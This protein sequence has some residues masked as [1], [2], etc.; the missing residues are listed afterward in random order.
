MRGKWIDS[1][2]V[3]YTLIHFP[4]DPQISDCD[5]FPKQVCQ[6]CWCITEAF[7]QLYVK[8][9]LAQDKFLERLHS[10]NE[11]DMT[12]RSETIFVEPM[13]EIVPIKCEIQ[14][15]KSLV[16]FN[17]FCAAE[18]DSFFSQ[19][20]WKLKIRKMIL[21]TAITMMAHLTASVILRKMWMFRMRNLRQNQNRNEN[22]D[23]QLQKKNEINSKR[24]SK[25][26]ADSSIWHANT[27]LQ[28]STHFM[29][30]NTITFLCTILV[31]AMFDVVLW[32]C[33]VDMKLCDTWRVI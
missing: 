14:L 21:M 22:Q 30:L 33:G 27:V 2:E 20:S 11:L 13:V 28:L 24:F 8:A 1:N 4:F 3:Y 5:S 26:T 10:K 29:M 19:M 6:K 17:R 7:H 16:I 25:S 32:N 9:K 18:K 15:G 31:L 23:E 12:Q